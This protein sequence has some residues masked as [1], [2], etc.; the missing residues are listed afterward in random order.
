MWIDHVEQ[1]EDDDRGQQKAKE[2]AQAKEKERKAKE[3]TGHSVSERSEKTAYLRGKGKNSTHQAEDDDQER[4]V[5]TEEEIDMGTL[6]GRC[7][8]EQE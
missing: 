4:H 3:E 8:G 6:V 7:R 5:Q 2:R 1:G